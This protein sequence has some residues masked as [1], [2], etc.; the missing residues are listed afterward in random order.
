M[1]ATDIQ[2]KQ[3]LIKY[4]NEREFEATIELADV[5][6]EAVCTIKGITWPYG[7]VKSIEV[8]LLSLAGAPA[9][10]FIPGIVRLAEEKLARHEDILVDVRSTVQYVLDMNEETGDRLGDLWDLAYEKARD[11]EVCNG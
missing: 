4:L 2:S 5:E 3:D 6:L 9:R 10:Y 1:T 11:K 7:E 8:D